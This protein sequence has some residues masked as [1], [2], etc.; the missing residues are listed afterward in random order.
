MEEMIYIVVESTYEDT[1]I[2]GVFDSEDKAN[3]V[4]EINKNYSIKIYELNRLTEAGKY[5]I[6]QYIKDL[7]EDLN[8][9]D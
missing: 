5:D 1:I 9:E 6:L 8:L 4:K 7:K 3:E 2:I